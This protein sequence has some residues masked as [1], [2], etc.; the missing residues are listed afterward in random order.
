[1]RRFALVAVAASA[2]MGLVVQAQGPRRGPQGPGGRGGQEIKIVKQFDKNGDGWLNAEERKAARQYVTS[3]GFG[4]ERGFGPRGGGRGGFGPAAKGETIRPADVK[5]YPN[6]PFYDES[7]LRTLFVT[8]EN[9]D[10]EREL[11]DFHGADVE[12]PATLLI[13]GK[14]YRDAGFRFRG[15]SSYFMAPEGRKRSFNVSIDMAHADQNVAGYRTLNLLNSNEDPTLMRA[16]LF[17]HVAR[18]Y[19]PAPK[20]NFVRVVINGASWGIYQNVQQFNKDFLKDNYKD[21]SGARWKTP[22]SPGG[23]AGL[24]Y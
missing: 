24:E 7:V 8:F 5:T 2:A 9:S 6:A 10:W 20:A 13:D 1:M 14:T 21:S 18:E 16:V 17:L 19:M 11:Q 3:Q 15:N 12:V 23:R 22:G 4:G